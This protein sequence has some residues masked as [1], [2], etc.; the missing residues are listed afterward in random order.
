MATISG[1]H[2]TTVMNERAELQ[3]KLDAA[4]DDNEFMT[5]H[6]TRML[7]ACEE[8]Y[9]RATNANIILERQTQRAAIKTKKEALKAKKKADKK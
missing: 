1:E 2:Y 6:Y 8:T 5:S 7:R 9:E 4:A 3:K